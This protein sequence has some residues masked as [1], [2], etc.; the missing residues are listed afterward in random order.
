MF[1]QGITHDEAVAGPFLCFMA[2]YTKILPVI[3]P[4]FLIAERDCNE[5]HYKLSLPPPLLRRWV[6]LD[7]TLHGMV[8]DGCIGRLQSALNCCCFTDCC[9][10]TPG[11]QHHISFVMIAIKAALRDRRRRRRILRCLLSLRDQRDDTCSINKQR[12]KLHSDT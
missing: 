11:L 8:H 3:Q 9:C 10:F 1:C 5:L 2:P 12:R 7:C 6:S 4:L